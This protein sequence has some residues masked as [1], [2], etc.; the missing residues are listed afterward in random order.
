MYRIIRIIKSKT[1]IKLLDVSSLMLGFTKE[2]LN[3][4]PL[5][6]KNKKTIPIKNILLLLYCLQLRKDI[7][8]KVNDIIV[9]PA[10]S[11]VLSI[12]PHT[13]CIIKE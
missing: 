4:T 12:S 10:K 6:K 1:Q 2:T 9:I 13:Y 8:I 11:I 7:V 3:K 5:I